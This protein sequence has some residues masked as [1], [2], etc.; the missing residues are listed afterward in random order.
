MRVYVILTKIDLHGVHDE[1]SGRGKH[2]AQE[3]AALGRGEHLEED[4]VEQR[5]G[6]QSLEDDGEGPVAGIRH[7]QHAD[8]D[9]DGRDE[10]ERGHGQ[11][12]PQAAR[13]G[14]DHVQA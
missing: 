9:A 10:G 7:E 5:A 11:D 13:P 1:E 12:E 4:D 6:G 8:R 14:R 3:S 2:E